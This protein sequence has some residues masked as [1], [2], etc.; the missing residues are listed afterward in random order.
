L[1]WS[2]SERPSPLSMTRRARREAPDG[3]VMWPHTVA[4]AAGEQAG[5]AVAGRAGA[6]TRDRDERITLCTPGGGPG[7]G[8]GMRLQENNAV[9][10]LSAQTLACA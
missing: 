10:V 4:R 2:F 9:Y 6:R 1:H 5:A 3:I 7:G 8:T